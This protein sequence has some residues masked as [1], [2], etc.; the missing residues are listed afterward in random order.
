VDD[1]ENDR[2]E[3]KNP[4]APALKL[5]AFHNFFGGLP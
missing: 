5:V 3:Q 2:Y 4:G 1:K